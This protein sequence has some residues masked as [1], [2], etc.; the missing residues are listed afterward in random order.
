MLGLLFRVEFVRV[1]CHSLGE[2]RAL[3]VDFLESWG[4]VGFEE[5]G[6]RVDFE[7]ELEKEGLIGVLRKL[8]DES[9]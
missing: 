2:A 9:S 7:E 8:F 5:E 3:F 1:F 6:V 4:T